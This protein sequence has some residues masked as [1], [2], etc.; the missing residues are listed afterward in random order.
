MNLPVTFETART[1]TE[2]CTFECSAS[3]EYSAAEAPAASR[4][5]AAAAARAGRSVL[6]GIGALASDLIRAER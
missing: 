3:S 4:H 6:D 5:S 2:N 1:G